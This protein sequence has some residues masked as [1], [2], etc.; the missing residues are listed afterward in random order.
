MFYHEGLVPAIRMYGD[1]SEPALDPQEA[2]KSLVFTAA[3]RDGV[4]IAGRST[5]E[6]LQRRTPGPPNDIANA[7]RRS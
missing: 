3:G 5:A 4:P 2:M 1:S 7:G 6:F